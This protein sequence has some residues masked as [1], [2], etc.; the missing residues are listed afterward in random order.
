[1]NNR[2]GRNIILAL[3]ITV[4]SPK[5]LYK[6]HSLIHN[7]PARKRC[8]ISFTGRMF[9]LAAKNIKFSVKI[10]TFLNIFR[11]ADKTLGYHRHTIPCAPAKDIG[12]HRNISPSKKLKPF[13]FA[14]IFKQF[15]SLG[16]DNLIRRKKEHSHTVIA[17][18]AQFNTKLRSG[19]LKKL[20]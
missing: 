16:T 20:V 11:A 7:R 8:N 17:F 2:Q 14:K 10:K 5:L 12:I 13:L 4:K 18:P 9:V 3:Q 15:L 19:F 1:M 6:E